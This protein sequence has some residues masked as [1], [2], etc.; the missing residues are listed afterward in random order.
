MGCVG[1]RANH[2][3]G[4]V[5]CLPALWGTLYRLQCSHAPANIARNRNYNDFRA[6]R[7]VITLFQVISPTRRLRI[8]LYVT[9]TT[10]YAA[11]SD[12]SSNCNYKKNSTLCNQTMCVMNFRP[13]DVIIFRERHSVRN[14]LFQITSRVI[15]YNLQ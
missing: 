9:L 8:P 12:I 4:R 11:P 13:S 14:N 15:S 3:G 6:T 2:R 10:A 5:S 7:I 1:S